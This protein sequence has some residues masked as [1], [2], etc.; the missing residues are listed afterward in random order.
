[1]KNIICMALAMVGL[2]GR[3]ENYPGDVDRYVPGGTNISTACVGAGRLIKIGSG[4]LTLSG[5][6]SAFTG[7]IVI[8]NGVVKAASATAL[9]TGPVTIVSQADGKGG[10]LQL[11]T[12]G[13]RF[14]NAITVVGAASPDRTEQIVFKAVGTL[15]GAITSACN[16]YFLNDTGL[17]GSVC[18]VEAPVTATN[19]EIGVKSKIGRGVVDFRQAVVCDSV[20]QGGNS[21]ASGYLGQARFSA[22]SS[23]AFNRIDLGYAGV[24]CGAANTLPENVVV[25]W[26]GQRGE[27]GRAV[28]YVRD[29][30]DQTVSS[31]GSA[32]GR[33]TCVVGSKPDWRYEAPA[34]TL[35]L[36]ARESNAAVCTFVQNVS[37]VYDA[38]DAAYV[39]AFSNAV[40]TTS[41]SITVKN[42]TLRFGGAASLQSVPA[43]HVQG[44]AFELDTTLPEALV[45]VVD[46]DVA[47]GAT[48]R[49]RGERPFS[50]S[51]KVKLSLASGSVLDLPDGYALQVAEFYLDGVKQGAGTYTHENCPEIAD[52]GVSVCVPG[53]LVFSMSGNCEIGAL[54]VDCVV[55]VLEGV[56]VTNVA[57]TSGAG[58]LIKIGPGTLVL[59]S[60]NKHE[61]GIQIAEGELV[62]ADYDSASVAGTGPIVVYGGSLVIEG[63]DGV[64]VEKTF[65]NDIR[66]AQATSS[67]VPGL[68]FRFTKVKT[69][70]F[71]IAL[72]GDM[73]ADGDLYIKED[74][75]KHWDEI[76]H[77]TFNGKLDA[78][79]HQVVY[80]THC[81][82]DWNGVVTAGTFAATGAYPTQGQHN[83]NATGNRIGLVKLTG[84]SGQSI[85]CGATNALDG[86]VDVVWSDIGEERRGHVILNGYDQRLGAV[87]GGCAANSINY[88]D[89]K[90]AELTLTGGVARASFNGKLGCLRHDGTVDD[91]GKTVQLSVTVDDAGDGS[92]VQDFSNNVHITYGTMRAKRGTLSF[93]GDNTSLPNVPEVIVDEEGT[94]ALDTAVEGA[95]PSVTNVTIA[96]GGTFRVSG[97]VQ[98]PFG[99][100][101]AIM[102][103]SSE[104]L[105]EIPEGAEVFV[106]RLFVD[107]VRKLKGDY[108]GEK[109]VGVAC[110]P[111]ITGKGVLH[112]RRGSG[113]THFILR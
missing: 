79:T 8:S 98:D 34:V 30:Y 50:D 67:A 1:M 40:H 104:G 81:G 70:K 17:L 11:A 18:P 61:G 93:S 37:L 52:N 97:R 26:D 25:Q 15:A 32:P 6:N 78:G 55:K 94:F 80:P 63:K 69:D 91:S 96:A 10:Q 71:Q 31:L 87:N 83:F 38:Q 21:N 42:G 59:N 110:L 103:L 39:Q 2:C 35:T 46:V 45:G 47:Q 4:T 29:G 12:E 99:K 76:K 89:W 85:S 3:A 5:D 36:K 53:E 7:G 82:V 105:L 16:L 49:V 73:T 48:L 84:R 57:P 33:T 92:F 14:E 41:G 106:E 95:M 13:A 66:F 54:A 28:F 43:L 60:E 88:R 24:E 111:Q 107:G 72:G 68:I 58:K 65:P 22:S 56:V 112:V 51:G 101:K 75:A 20:Y 108:S 100:A 90:P 27:S 77:I 74:T 113:G 9:G 23:N 109:R 86:V 102:S 19:C 62:V 44:G 64:T